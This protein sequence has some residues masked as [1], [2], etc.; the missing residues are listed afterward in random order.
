MQVLRSFVFGAPGCERTIRR[1]GS[2]AAAYPAHRAPCRPAPMLERIVTP[3]PIRPCAYVVPCRAEF[4]CQS[5][6]LAHR[7][8]RVISGEFHCRISLPL[9]LSL[10]SFV[11]SLSVSPYVSRNWKCPRRTRTYNPLIKSRADWD[12][13]L[14]S[15][16]LRDRTLSRFWS[17][18]GTSLLSTFYAVLSGFSS[19]SLTEL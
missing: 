12:E 10:N 6:C 14:G 3:T 19:V 17:R 5:K 11:E 7:D 18:N 16:S 1:S 15:N 2:F 4:Y 8:L 13:S 9:L